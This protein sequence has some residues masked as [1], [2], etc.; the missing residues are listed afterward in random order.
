MQIYLGNV[1]N[2]KKGRTGW[3]AKHLINASVIN[4]EVLFYLPLILLVM[5]YQKLSFLL[6]TRSFQIITHHPISFSWWQL[7]MKLFPPHLSSL[8]PTID[9]IPEDLIWQNFIQIPSQPLGSQ[10]I[11]I[12]LNHT[13][14]FII[15]H[16]APIMYLVLW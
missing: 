14:L 6:E 5:Y 1:H 2:E 10:S 13:S 7:R 15:M 3:Q 9:Y 8:F 12:V 4:M 11:K 16:F